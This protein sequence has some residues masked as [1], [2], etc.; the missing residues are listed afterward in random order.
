MPLLIRNGE[1]VTADSRFHADIY[2]ENETITRIGN[3]SR[4]ACRD[5]GHRCHREAR[6]PR[7]HRSARPHLPAI[8]GDIREGYT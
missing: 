2:V 6:L 8:H 3:E 7:I 4:H 1:I 5:R